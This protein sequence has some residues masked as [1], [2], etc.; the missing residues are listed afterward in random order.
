VNIANTKSGNS[1]VLAKRIAIVGAPGS[2]K[3]TFAVRLQSALRLPLY[4]LDDLYW[5]PNWRRTEPELF[6]AAQREIVDREEWII[7]GN[8]MDT[9]P[10][11]LARADAICV[12]DVSPLMAARGFLLRALHRAAGRR[13]S[14]PVAV[15]LDEHYIWRP[16][17]DFR[18]MKT[19]LFFRA[20]IRPSIFRLISQTPSLRAVIVL[21]GRRDALVLAKDVGIAARNGN[22]EDP[23]HCPALR[24]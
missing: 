9:L 24:S 4:H 8:H 17:I 20:T 18:V 6:A 16:R 3:S 7:D 15:R 10:I 11:R 5:L 2:G 12:F 14:L 22:N 13:D 1:L 19:L 23:L 21:R